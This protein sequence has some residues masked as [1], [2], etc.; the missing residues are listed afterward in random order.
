METT[1]FKILEVFNNS[2]YRDL[3]RIKLHIFLVHQVVHRSSLG[4]IIYTKVL[5]NV[6]EVLVG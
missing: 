5:E 3:S 2:N 1:T 4:R 6:H